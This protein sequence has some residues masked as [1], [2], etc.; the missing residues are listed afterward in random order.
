MKTL[1]KLL[2]SFSIATAAA[3]SAC[4]SVASLS[5]SVEQEWIACAAADI[6]TGLLQC[7]NSRDEFV[8]S[9]DIAAAE[10]SRSKAQIQL[11]S[12]QMILL[13]VTR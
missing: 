1:H 13:Q 8:R 10:S 2:N 9:S 3:T 12:S 5:S 7:Q 6:K 11:I 4:A